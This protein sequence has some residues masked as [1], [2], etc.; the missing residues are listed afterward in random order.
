[1]S[2]LLDNATIAQ[3]KDLEIRTRILA[4]GAIVGQHPSNIRG[5]GIEFNQYRVYEPGDDPGK[6]DWKLFSRNDR[7]FV[8]EAEKE[9]ALNV[10]GMLDCSES[11][12]EQSRDGH[13]DKLAFA[14][15]L[16]AALAYLSH[17]QGDAI[18]M[19]ALNSDVLQYLPVRHGQRHY[20]QY[21]L[22]LEKLTAV[23]TFPKWETF[24]QY[25]HSVR[26]NSL[27]ILVSD[28]Y[29]SEQE[30]LSLAQNLSNF[31]CEVLA[32]QLET[33]DEVTFDFSGEIQFTERESGR[34]QTVSAH[35]IQEE[36]LLNRALFNEN[37]TN[38]LAKLGIKHVKVNI[39]QPIVH[40]L[41]VVASTLSNMGAR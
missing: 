12:H 11:M 37:L 9:S 23:N 36:Y 6:I 21:L 7:Y 25:V 38:Q 15:N 31:H 26:Q 22:Q 35:A 30:L 27:V 34:K 17:Q 1:M 4:Q 28:F 29:E 32:I 13:W 24:P 39:D 5:V 40:A 10:W 19:L 2:E 16:L 3:I 8:R 41:Q 33:N 20:H 18:G 14:K